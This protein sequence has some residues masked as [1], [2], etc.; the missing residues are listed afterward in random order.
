MFLVPH[1]SKESARDSYDEC[2]GVAVSLWLATVSAI[3]NLLK[4]KTPQIPREGYPDKSHA[5]KSAEF[6]SRDL[7]SPWE[8]MSAV[9]EIC[10]DASGA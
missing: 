9:L 4:K 3:T 2:H 1:R 10:S 6:V 8:R 5:T 7:S